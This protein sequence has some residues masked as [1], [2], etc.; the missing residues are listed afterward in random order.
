MENVKDQLK[1]S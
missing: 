1:I